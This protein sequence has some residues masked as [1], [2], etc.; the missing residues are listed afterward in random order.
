LGGRTDLANLILLCQ[1]HHTAVHE[2]GLRIRKGAD[3]WLF[4]KPDGQSCEPW[5][6]DENLAR[7]LDY[8]HC[9]AQQETARR[10]RLAAVDSF[11]HPD[12]HTIRP[13]WTGEPFDLHAC[14]QALFTIKLP[15]P[16]EDQDQQA[17]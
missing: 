10:D 7:H 8:A 15:Q 3:G 14:V 1:W 17:A 11:H 12:A 13:R 2:G 9:R 16:N 4:S 5:L 6:S